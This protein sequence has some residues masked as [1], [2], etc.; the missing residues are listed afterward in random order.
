[1]MG[2]KTSKLNSAAENLT[3]IDRRSNLSRKELFKEYIEPEIPVI[4]TDATKNWNAI[5]KLTPEFFKTN[6]P[7]ITKEIKNKK[8]TLSELID[9][10]QISTAEKPAPYPFN[11]NI[12]NYLPELLAD[13]KP[14]IVYGKLDR[15]NHPLLPKFLL[16]GTDVYEFFFGGKGASFPFLH[17]DALYMHTQ[18]TQVYG[19]KE[20]IFY[21][22]GQSQLLY[23]RPGSPQI[24]Q[25]DIFNPDYEKFPLFKQARQIRCMVEEGDTLLFPTGWWHTTQ[26]HGP[27]ITMG[28]A[29]LNASNW[30]KFINDIYGHW[31]VLHPNHPNMRIPALVCAKILGTVMSIQE[32]FL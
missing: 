12:E 15:I 17:Y 1:M 18:I 29:Q 26:I 27:S 5:G 13:I 31:K 14:E 11:L 32:A 30:Q 24:S 3:T 21:S 4:L 10:I 23:P 7:E 16:N 20:F 25:V 22:P 28:R 19:S 2:L 9:L 6:Y 8:Y